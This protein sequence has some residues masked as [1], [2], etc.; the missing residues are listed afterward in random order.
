MT[1]LFVFLNLLKIIVIMLN[2]TITLFRL[3]IILVELITSALVIW[4]TT[5]IKLNQVK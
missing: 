4:E 1:F 3:F 2:I 5:E